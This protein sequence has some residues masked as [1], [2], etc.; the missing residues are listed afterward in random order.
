MQPGT[1]GCSPV[2]RVWDPSGSCHG[3][4]FSDLEGPL[5][6]LSAARCSSDRVFWKA[7]AKH[8]AKRLTSYSFHT[9]APRGSSFSSALASRHAG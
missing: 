7:V 3:G 5:K 9:A 4:R 6:L 2:L 8:E 1:R